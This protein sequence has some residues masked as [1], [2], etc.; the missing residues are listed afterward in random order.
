VTLKLQ[1]FTRMSSW[2]CR[3]CWRRLV[4]PR[5]RSWRL[6][7]RAVVFH[8]IFSKQ[9]QHTQYT[10]QQQFLHQRTSILPAS[11]IHSAGSCLPHVKPYSTC[12][13]R[14]FCGMF[15]ESVNCITSNQTKCFTIKSLLFCY[16]M[17]NP[18]NIHVNITSVIISQ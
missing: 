11:E 10:R 9:P 2:R 3:S 5:D 4:W 7:L 8:S 1:R 16:A 17:S 13:R 6:I 12:L 14:N 18:L 15:P